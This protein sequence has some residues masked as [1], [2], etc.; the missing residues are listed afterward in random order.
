M[1]ARLGS[2]EVQTGHQLQHCAKLPPTLPDML[3]ACLRARLGVL[4]VLTGHLQAGRLLLAAE[5][6]LPA[7][8]PASEAAEEP[9]AVVSLFTGSGAYQ[10]DCMCR[11]GTIV[12]GPWLW[13]ACLEACAVMHDCQSGCVCSGG[14]LGC[15]E[16]VS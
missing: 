6:G 11:Q 15:S 12:K 9:M 14:A 13:C 8:A 4:E 7:E 5:R 16:G 1:H 3:R 2:L 10:H